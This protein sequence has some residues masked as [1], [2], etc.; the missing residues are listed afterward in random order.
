MATMHHTGR[1]PAV[2]AAKSDA[3]AFRHMEAA[4]EQGV[5]KAM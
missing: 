5:P 2:S 4:A 1:T 3:E